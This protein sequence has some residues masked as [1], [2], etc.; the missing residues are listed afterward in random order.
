MDGLRVGSASL[1]NTVKVWNVE[2]GKLLHTLEGHDAGVFRVA[3]HGSRVVSGSGDKTVRFWDIADIA[4]EEEGR[5]PQRAGEG[6][7]PRLLSTHKHDEYPRA[8]A[9]DA[10][11]LVIAFPDKIIVWENREGALYRPPWFYK[12]KKPPVYKEAV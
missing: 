12:G 5:E 10:S 8:L 4:V 11:R 7:D 3:I 2:T 6:P 1:D 9:M